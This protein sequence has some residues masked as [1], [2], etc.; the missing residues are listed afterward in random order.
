MGFLPVLS[1][2]DVG[3]ADGATFGISRARGGGFGEGVWR[4]D[5]RISPMFLQI[6]TKSRELCYTCGEGGWQWNAYLL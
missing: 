1:E 4:F 3:G 5:N 6:Q 2:K